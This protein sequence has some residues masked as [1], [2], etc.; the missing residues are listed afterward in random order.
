MASDLLASSWAKFHWAKKHLETLNEASGGFFEL[1]GQS[2]ALKV[3][4][5]VSA[6]TAVVLV[7]PAEVPDVPIRCA[8]MVGDILQNLRATLDHMVWDLVT[9]V[10]RRPARPKQVQFPMAS[11]ARDWGDRLE[12]RLPHIPMGQRAII[13]EYQPYRRGDGP[14]NIRRLRNFSDH[15]K[16]RVLMPTF[17]APTARNFTVHTNWMVARMDYLVKDGARLKRGAQF[18]RAELLRGPSRDACQVYV[19][20]NT[21]VH[22]AFRQGLLVLPTLYEIRET[23]LE[24]LMRF[25]G[26]IS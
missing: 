26:E 5:Q 3:D 16:H 21:T 4:Q 11:S 25:E 17:F 2:L 24:I 7:A 1:E 13:R 10:N 9:L 23:V 19:E 14:R 22:P 15:D 12:D 6:D 8:L 20:G 18:L